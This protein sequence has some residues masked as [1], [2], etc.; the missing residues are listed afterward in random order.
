METKVI[1]ADDHSIVRMGLISLIKQFNV[2][3]VD[4]VATC[5][6][7]M[8]QL[9]NKA[10]TH[11]ILDLILPDGNTLEIIE[12][13]NK[14]YPKLSILIHSMQ[15]IE[16]Y[17]KI[18]KKYHIHSY[19]YK[20]VLENEIKYHIE[21]FIKSIPLVM[22]KL[23]DNEEN[24]FATL[25]VR[26]LEVLHYLL[27]GYRTKEISALLGLKMNT[28]STIKSVIFDKV[29]ADSFTHLLQLA[30]VHQISY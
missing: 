8:L 10:Y 23:V 7:L 16:V 28:I 22:S 5:H 3:V 9:K 6:E 24:P 29:K 11:L 30:H 25:A 17:G 18:L 20:G 27:N 15:P 19:L 26:E 14:L 12:N 13:I 21:S 1:I 4:E 2:Q